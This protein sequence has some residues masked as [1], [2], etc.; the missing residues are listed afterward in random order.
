MAKRV[1]SWLAAALAAWSISAAPAFAG[2]LEIG[3]ITVQMVGQERT[4]TL[5]VH[6]TAGDP[7]TVQVR[8]VD[9]SQSQAGDVYAPSTTLVASPALITLGP[10]ETQTVRLVLENVAQAPHEQSYR[11]ILDEI[12]H[13]GGTVPAGLKTAVRI[14]VPVFLSLSLQGRPQVRWSAQRTQAGLVVTAHND[15]AAR[16]RVS[17]FVLSSGSQPLGANAQLEGYVLSG[18][19]RSWTLPNAPTAV[20]NVTISGQGAY[21]PVNAHATV[22]G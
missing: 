5:T 4:S 8:T 16:E 13:A 17:G 15:G 22:G 20:T 1:A 11:L 6:N 21:G 18:S 7:I 3:P 14:L 9:W 19:T 12:P 2:G 10:G